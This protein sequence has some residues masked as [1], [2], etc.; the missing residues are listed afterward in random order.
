MKAKLTLTLDADL[1]HRARRSARVRGLSLS[2]LVEAALREIVNEPTVSFATRWR[3]RFRPAQRDDGRF[4][5]LS[6]KYL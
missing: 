2:S 5:A 4:R 6:R 1:L 3:G